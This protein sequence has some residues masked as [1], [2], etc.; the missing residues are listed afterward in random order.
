MDTRRLKEHALLDFVGLT[1][2]RIWDDGPDWMAFEGLEIT[3][4]YHSWD[5]GFAGL[6]FLYGP[7]GRTPL[8]EEER[9]I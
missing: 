5:L 4:P 6:I 1:F 2:L 8:V 3:E 9:G 7:P